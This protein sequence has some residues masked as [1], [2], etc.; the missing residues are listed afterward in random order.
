MT[1]YERLFKYAPATG[2]TQ[3][4]NFLSES[5]CDVLERMTAFDRESME[6]FVLETVLKEP[7]QSTFS[8]RLLNVGIPN[9][10]DQCSGACRSPVP[11]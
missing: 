2:R 3:L 10:A 7:A 11:G 9:D 6:G 5:L 4:E 1:L 8:E